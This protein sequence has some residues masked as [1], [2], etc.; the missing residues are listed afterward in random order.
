[1]VLFPHTHKKTGRGDGRVVLVVR[2]Q[3]LV[4]KIMEF[5]LLLSE[6]VYS[7]GLRQI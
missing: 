4:K 3:E 6:S 1:M 5:D 2:E 7:H